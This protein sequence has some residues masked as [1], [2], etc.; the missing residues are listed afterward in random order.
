MMGHYFWDGSTL[1]MFNGKLE[2]INSYDIEE[3]LIKLDHDAA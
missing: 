1:F 2:W 3:I